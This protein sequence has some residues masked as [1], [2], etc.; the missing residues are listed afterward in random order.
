MATPPGET[1]GVEEHLSDADEVPRVNGHLDVNGDPSSGSQTPETPQHQMADPPSPEAL[2]ELQA[3]D[4]EDFESRYEAALL[5]ASEEEKVILKE[6]ESLSKVHIQRVL[7]GALKLTKYQYFQ[8]WAAAA[9]SHDDARAVK[10]L[11]T[12][13]RFVNLSEEKLSQKQQHCSYQMESPGVLPLTFFQTSKLS[14]PL[15]VR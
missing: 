3:F 4:W 11:Q 9:S 2:E 12:R 5:R 7:D 10:R 8:A 6:A 1:N 15:R 14:G 13:Q